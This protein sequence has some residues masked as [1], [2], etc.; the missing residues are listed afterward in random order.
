MTLR[1][2]ERDHVAVHIE[3]LEKTYGDAPAAGP[4]DLS[5]EPGQSVLVL[6]HN[7]SGKSTLLSMIAGVVEPTAG[8]AWIFGVEPGS[9]TGRA[10]VSYL[11]DTPVLY[12]DLSVREH[13]RYISRL[14][15][16]DEDDTTFD[17]LVE[18]VGLGARADDLPSTFSRGLRQRT[19]IALAFCRP[20]NVLL[21]DE[22]FVGL[23]AAGRDAFVALL[24]ETRLRGAT[25]LV[26]TH[27][28]ARLDHFDRR[29]ELRDGV[30]VADDGA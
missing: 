28:P 5:V 12:D 27:D 14:H 25:V 9:L 30:V 19:A 26:A 6:G 11:P 24:D 13:V 1:A 22:P 20:F 7:G 21:V 10:T 18:R 29:V 3:G 15:G 8:D 17:A 23:D 4:I 16:A 2:A